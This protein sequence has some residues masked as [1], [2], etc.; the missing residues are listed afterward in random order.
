[1]EICLFLCNGQLHVNRFSNA[2]VLQMQRLRK[3]FRNWSRGSYTAL[4]NFHRCTTGFQSCSHFFPFQ[5]SHNLFRR[6]C[7]KYLMNFSPTTTQ[8]YLISRLSLFFMSFS[9]SFLMLLI[10]DTSLATDIALNLR[11]R[12]FNNEWARLGKIVWS[13]RGILDYWLNQIVSSVL[14]NSCKHFSA[15]DE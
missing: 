4:V 6:E 7:V 14:H 9:P 13:F 10:L 2:A 8:L 15:L 3:G 1:M 11:W 12:H 5:L